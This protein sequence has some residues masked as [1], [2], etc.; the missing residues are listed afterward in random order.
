[1]E[2]V[3]SAGV[4]ETEQSGGAQF[5]AN[6]FSMWTEK[7]ERVATLHPADTLGATVCSPACLSLVLSS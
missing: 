5:K 6:I 1:M 2:R 3:R 7:T 4:G